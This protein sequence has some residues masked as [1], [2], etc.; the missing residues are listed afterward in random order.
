MNP[1]GGGGG[2]GA[3]STGRVFGRACLLGG[4]TTMAISP[5]RIRP[6][7]SRARCSRKSGFRRRSILAVSRLFERLISCRSLAISDI[8][9][10]CS[11]NLRVGSIAMAA[12]NP[13][14][15]TPTTTWGP[16]PRRGSRKRSFLAIAVTAYPLERRQ[17]RRDIAQSL[18]GLLRSATTGCTSRCVHPVRARRF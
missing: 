12:S 11:N 8:R 10:R 6:I 14:T 16:I 9:S 18:R 4:I 13:R 3:L 5:G 7:C 2:G 1:R 17:S 15:S